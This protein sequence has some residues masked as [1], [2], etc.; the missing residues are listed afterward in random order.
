MLARIAESTMTNDNDL[1]NIVNQKSITINENI[2]N[3]KNKLLELPELKEQSEDGLIIE[4]IKN[5]RDSTYNQI[6]N[7]I[8]TNF[9]SISSNNT[10]NNTGTR[11][12]RINFSQRSHPEQTSTTTKDSD[13][14]YSIEQ[15]SLIDYEEQYKKL[16]SE[17]FSIFKL[18]TGDDRSLHGKEHQSV[19]E[20]INESVRYIYTFNNQKRPFVSDIITDSIESHPCG[21]TSDSGRFIECV[22]MMFSN[23]IKDNFNKKLIPQGEILFKEEADELYKLIWDGFQLNRFTGWGEYSFDKLSEKANLN[24]QL[25]DLFDLYT[26]AYEATTD[27]ISLFTPYD[28]LLN[29][30]RKYIANEDKCNEHHKETDTVIDDEILINTLVDLIRVHNIPKMIVDKATDK[31]RRVDNLR[32]QIIQEIAPQTHFVQNI[33][34]LY[35]LPEA[36]P[37]FSR[38]LRDRREHNNNVRQF[39]SAKTTVVSLNEIISIAIPTDNGTAQN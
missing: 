13:V 22:S 14:S 25:K 16:R 2:R 24:S 1:I 36:A 4:V 5:L 37:V 11:R 35:R 34:P 8:N 3:L 38:E 31:Q 10:S 23:K 17:K 7:N 9:G 6:S 39:N 21:N 32:T 20:E 30:Y 33:L 15:P 29:Y 26:D 12:S 27:P 28:T 18:L 19:K